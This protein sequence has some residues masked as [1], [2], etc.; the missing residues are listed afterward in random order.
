MSQES[1]PPSSS[2][3]DD[4]IDVDI[5]TMQGIPLSSLSTDQQDA[6]GSL[7]S[8]VLQYFDEQAKTEQKLDLNQSTVDT[9]TIT[10]AAG[11]LDGMISDKKQEIEDDRA[12]LYAR[13]AYSILTTEQAQ[14]IVS[15]HYYPGSTVLSVKHLHG[16]LSNSNYKVVIEL[17]TGENIAVLL[18][19]NDEKNAH[20]LQA[21]LDVV[22][23]LVARSYPTP[24]C[25]PS[26]Q[27]GKDLVLFQDMRITCFE[28]MPGAVPTKGSDHVMCALGHW[29]AELHKVQELPE[30]LPDFPMGYSQMKPFCEEEVLDSP[31]KDHEY[32]KY[33]VRRKTGGGAG[34]R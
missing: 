33:V 12:A 16:G 30:S 17:V 18:K 13:P 27:H 2:N 23:L 20:E 34:R 19:V 26:V 29:L 28:F 3:A 14:K 10:S 32:V 22:R 15:T 8:R 31:A 25:L 21:Q 24:K 4:D 7:A 1:N 5:F 11:S 6:I 9:T